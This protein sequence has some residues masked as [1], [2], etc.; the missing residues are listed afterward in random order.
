MADKIPQVSFENVK[1]LAISTKKV[2]TE[3]GAKPMTKF[4]FEVEARPEDIDRL[5]YFMK[6]KSTMNV[7]IESH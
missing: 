1:K 6:Q 2:V 5:M 4:S 3:T 7:I